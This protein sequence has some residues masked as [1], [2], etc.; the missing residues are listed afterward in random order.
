[1]VHEWPD[2]ASLI[3]IHQLSIKSQIFM[4]FSYPRVSLPTFVQLGEKIIQMDS[5][6]EDTLARMKTQLQQELAKKEA[7]AKL[8]STIQEHWEAR[9]LSIAT[10]EANTMTKTNLVSSPSVDISQEH[11]GEFEKH[12]KGIGSKLLR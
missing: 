1:M 7:L 10:T 12:T 9:P 6:Q 2:G 8:Q 11:L 5:W 4:Y 3:P